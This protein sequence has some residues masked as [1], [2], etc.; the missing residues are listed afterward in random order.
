MTKFL[1]INLTMNFY[2]PSINIVIL[3]D[4]FVCQKWETFSCLKTMSK[5]IVYL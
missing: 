5:F 2:K 4:I 3:L 1:M